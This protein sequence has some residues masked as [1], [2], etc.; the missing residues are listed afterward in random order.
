MRGVEGKS[1]T[2]YFSA[3]YI[4][5]IIGVVF[6]LGAWGY[7]AY[8]ADFADRGAHPR[9]DAITTLIKGAQSYY[10]RTGSYPE[11]FYKIEDL[12]WKHGA[13]PDYGERG[14]TLEYKN[15]YYLYTRAEDHVATLW[16][17]PIGKYREE[18]PTYFVILRSPKSDQPVEK[19]KGA[20]LNM[21]EA[22]KI[23]G[24]P[25]FNQLGVLGMTRMEAQKKSR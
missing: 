18:A 15:Y 19:W 22:A 3:S 20:A 5:A 11:N 10:T 16:A 23:S 25:T 12:V 13:M 14:V 7:S 2:R 9:L 1:G 24:A 17:I 21:E 4:L 8:S 6:Y